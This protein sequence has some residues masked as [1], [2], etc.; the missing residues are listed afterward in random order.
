MFG[1][2]GHHAEWDKPDTVRQIL[3]A[4]SY[5]W[6]LKFEKYEKRDKE[7]ISVC[8]AALLQI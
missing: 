1:T 4:L 8:S 2:G 7:D 6:E 3:H 5:L